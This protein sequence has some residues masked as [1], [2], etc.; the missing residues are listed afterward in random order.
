MVPAV[1]H[2]HRSLLSVLM[3]SALRYRLL[4]LLEHQT[5]RVNSGLCVV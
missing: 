2:M 3:F 4:C 1:V 5:Y